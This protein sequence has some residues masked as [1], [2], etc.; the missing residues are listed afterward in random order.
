MSQPADPDASAGESAP[1]VE[2]FASILEYAAR[3]G[4]RHIWMLQQLARLRERPE[5]WIVA[6]PTRI[7]DWHVG[8]IVVGPPGIFLIWPVA[9]RVEPGLWETLMQCHAHV[10]RGL[11]EQSHAVE[12][13]VFSPTHDRGRMQRWM[14]SEFDMLT[15]YGHNL[16][17]LLAEWHPVSGV[18]LGERWISELATASE[19][20]EALYGPDT[21]AQQKYPRWSPPLARIAP[22]P[23]M[24]KDLADLLQGFA[25]A[26]PVSSYPTEKPQRSN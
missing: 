22:D 7:E 15:A 17:H 18:Y 26:D 12:S 21:G 24:T 8:A 16:D 13:V 14:D 19:P 10:Q 5:P 9:T 23:P 20:R 2:P 25:T 11:G 4:P 6:G 1:A 3:L